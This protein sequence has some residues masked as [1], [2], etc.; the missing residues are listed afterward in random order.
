M[1]VI[2]AVDLYK[3][4]KKTEAVQGI[5]FEVEKGEIFG[6]LGPNGAGKTTTIRMLTAQIKPDKGSAQVLGHDIIRDSDSIRGKIG[7][8]FEDQN[9]YPRLRIFF[10]SPVYMGREKRGLNRFSNLRNFPT[11]RKTKPRSCPE[12]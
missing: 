6:F 8:V 12:V 10:F 3:K 1:S 4:Y 7:V 5:S 11:D 2:N 9:V